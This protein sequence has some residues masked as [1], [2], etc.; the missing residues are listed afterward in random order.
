MYCVKCGVRLADSEKKCPLCGTVV[1]HP[2]L[3]VPHG[4]PTFPNL[5]PEEFHPTPHGVQAIFT[6]VF[7]L[8][9]V[10][11]LVI[12]LALRRR[13]TWSGYAAGGIVLAYLTMILP[14]WFRRPNPIIF[15]AVDFAALG[16]YLLY[17]DLALQGGWFLSFAFPVVG[18]TGLLVEAVVT[19]CHCLRR[20]HLYVWGG[21]FIALGCCM[22]LFEL[23]QVITFG[24]KMFRWSLY[25]LTVLCLVG[26][27]LLLVAI[28]RP[29]RERMHKLFLV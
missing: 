7:A 3:P 24:G 22:M 1:Y 10:L 23:F 2:D 5:G 13:V 14:F 21:A 26:L 28:I 4:E 11:C 19:L 20:G 8:A 18:I 16:C 29:L 25:P 9:A 15:T 27:F 12:D 6:F 17:I